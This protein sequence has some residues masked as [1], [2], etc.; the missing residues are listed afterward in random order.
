MLGKLEVPCGFA[1]HEL[2][3][4]LGRAGVVIV[5]VSL[6]VHS[7][8]LDG[9]ESEVLECLQRSGPVVL[10]LADFVQEPGVGSSPARWMFVNELVDCNN[11]A[12]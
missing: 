1:V 10:M 7:A 9:H 5:R 8:A 3:G 4:Y 2:H 11:I 12:H 6:G